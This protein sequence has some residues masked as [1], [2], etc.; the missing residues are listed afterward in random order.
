MLGNLIRGNWFII[1]V[2][3][4]FNREF[5]TRLDNFTIESAEKNFEEIKVEYP[6][7]KF[8]LLLVVSR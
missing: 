7:K 5:V 4:H 6:D 2:I 3:N 8:E 1:E